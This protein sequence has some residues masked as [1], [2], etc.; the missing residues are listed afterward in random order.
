MGL[1][2]DRISIHEARLLLAFQKQPGR[3]LT[4]GLRP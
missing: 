4:N 3:W 1:A 2:T